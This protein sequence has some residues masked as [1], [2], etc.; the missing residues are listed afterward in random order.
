MSEHAFSDLPQ[1]AWEF[2]DCLWMARVTSMSEEWLCCACEVG[3]DPWCPEFLKAFI[4][5]FG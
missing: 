4:T 1:L 5:M 3:V 2:I